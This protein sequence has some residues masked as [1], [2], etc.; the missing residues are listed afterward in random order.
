MVGIIE[1]EE[2]MHSI[3]KVVA[4]VDAV[5]RPIPTYTYLKKELLASGLT[6]LLAD[7]L[8]T[9][10]RRNADRQYEFVYTTDTIR[11]M[12]KTYRQADYW[13]VIG[14]P[15]PGCHI[16]LVRAEKNHIWTEDI[17]ER[18]DILAEELKGRFSTRLVKDSGHWLQ[19]DNPEGLYDAIS[20]LLIS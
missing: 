16:R 1:D 13:D 3:N 18:L 6:P 14:N 9:S 2:A 19:V 20:D 15:P 12:L 5:K 10:V 17:I 7:W 8:S 11:S 4:A